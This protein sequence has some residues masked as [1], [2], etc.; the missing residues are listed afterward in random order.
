MSYFASIMPDSLV[1]TLMG[2]DSHNGPMQA[3]TSGSAILGILV[4]NDCVLLKA[5][6]AEG[7]GTHLHK[8][9]AIF[10]SCFCLL[11]IL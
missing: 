5:H 1:I 6:K 10:M 4:I 3:N 8:T 2:D 11:S 7:R 9:H